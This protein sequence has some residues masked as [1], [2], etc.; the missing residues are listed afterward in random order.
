MKCAEWSEQFCGYLLR[1]SR[2]FFSFVF[3][4]HLYFYWMSCWKLFNIASTLGTGKLH[5]Q[6]KN[7]VIILLFIFSPWF[8]LGL[9]NKNHS[10]TKFFQL[11]HILYA[12]QL[13]TEEIF[14]RHNVYV[15]NKCIYSVCT[16]YDKNVYLPSRR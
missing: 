11:Q 10:H 9:N 7:S 6:N 8:V 4:F 3:F 12:I 5:D 16:Y 15:Y 2:H 13:Q 14:M 1:F